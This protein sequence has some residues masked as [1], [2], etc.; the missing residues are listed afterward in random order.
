MAAS[1][2]SAHAHAAR[3]P[4][5]FR[6]PAG[7]VFVRDGTLFRE[8]TAEGAADY[9]RLMGSGLY[10]VLVERGLLVPHE[11]DA[12]AQGAGPNPPHRVLRP[13]LVPFLSWPYEW[14]FGMLQAAALATLEV[15]RLA[16]DRGMTLKDASAY[17]VQFLDGRPTLVDTTSFDILREGEPWVAYRQFC[18]HFLAP[19]ALMSYVDAR[20]GQLLRV[21]LDGVP[22]DLAARLLPR[23]ARWR[24][25]LALHLVAHARHQTKHEGT[26]R[27][28]T[29]RVSRNARLGLLDS[30]TG[31]VRALRWEPEG[32][33]WADYGTR[34]S[35]DETGEAHKRETVAAFLDEV[36]PASVWDLGANAGGYSRLAAERGA[37]VVAPDMDPAAVERNW[38]SCQRDDE[39][40]VLPLLVDLA[41]PSPDQ[42]W[43]GE[44]RASFLARGPADCA[45]ALA[46]VHHLAIGNNVP[47][48]RV[49][50]FLARCGRGVV[51]E[52][53]PKED[54]Q[55]ARM[56]ASRR[57]VFP[58][59]TAVAFEA[60]LAERFDVRRRVPL[61]GST[62]VLYLCERRE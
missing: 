47:L 15:Q 44:E 1:A 20:M 23:R 48:P 35:Y 7:F 57:D 5:S 51:V 36:R 6:D 14:S 62:R 38:R 10:R 12:D 32:T 50:D 52:W 22:L 33:T 41:N 31:A 4:A 54:P 18:Q 58:D 17:N 39:R 28:A 9:D 30:L 26:A 34:T 21:H 55:V 45:F 29:G 13:R 37:L 19:L 49:A 60:A 24:P 25:A 43:A 11:E 59:Y 40:R 46:L 16:L 53:V 27:R 56:L 42:G 61:R 3:H 8:V 2:A